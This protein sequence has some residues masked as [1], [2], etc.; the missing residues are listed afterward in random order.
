M[1]FLLTFALFTGIQLE[2]M[3]DCSLKLPSNVSAISFFFF[4][5]FVLVFVYDSKIEITREEREILK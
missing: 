1:V 5:L 4:G 3:V 2:F